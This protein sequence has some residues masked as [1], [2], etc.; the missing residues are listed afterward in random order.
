MA[1]LIADQAVAYAVRPIRIQLLDEGG[2]KVRLPSM[3]RK[4]AADQA[5][6]GMV[7]NRDRF[8]LCLE[9]HTFR[10]ERRQHEHPARPGKGRSC[11]DWPGPARESFRGYATKFSSRWISPFC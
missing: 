7:A 8:R 6:H 1:A 4:V 10:G 9:G 11:S 3:E 2:V 5:L